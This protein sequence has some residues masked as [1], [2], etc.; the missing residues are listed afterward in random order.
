MQEFMHEFEEYKTLSPFWGWFVLIV[1]SISI[2]TFGMIAH[3]VIPHREQRHWD[4]GALPIVP[5]ESRF[6]TRKPPAKPSLQ[7]IPLPGA[8][9]LTKIPA[10]TSEPFST[11]CR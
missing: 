7:M 10:D 2:I 8:N 3:M 1:F 6:T 4:F 5:G 9:P 11:E